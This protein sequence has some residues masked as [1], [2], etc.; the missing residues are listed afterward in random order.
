MDELRSVTH[1]CGLISCDI[2]FLR[3]RRVHF[4]FLSQQKLS[5]M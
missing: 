2:T 3:E 5:L 1:A 4:K